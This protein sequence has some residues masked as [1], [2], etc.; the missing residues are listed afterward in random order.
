MK[1]TD[2]YEILGVAKNSPEDE[3]KKA[4]RKLAMKYHPDRN[5]DDDKDAAEVKFKEIKE[6]YECLSD[7]SRKEQYDRHG[8]SSAHT[9]AQQWNQDVNADEFKEMFANMFGH[10]SPFG[11]IFGQQTQPQ[12]KRHVV[13]MSLEDAYKGRVV[14]LQNGTSFNIPAGVRTG[15]RIFL[16]NAIYQINV[17]PHIKFKRANDDLLI[18]VEISAIEAMLS[19]DAQLDHLD[20]SKLQFTIPAGIQNGQVVRLA[21]KGMKNPETNRF[22]D[23]MIRITVTTP[24]D[25]T[26]EQRAFL[27]TMQHRD[28]FNI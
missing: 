16:D 6:A 4:Y 13:N 1:K 28:L 20:D 12:H 18:D 22:G 26:E 15:T 11:D 19:V 7:P 17:Q 27:K 21:N 10:N 3:I 8:H 5:A 14:Q 9:N 23:L 25:L 24:R 2:Y